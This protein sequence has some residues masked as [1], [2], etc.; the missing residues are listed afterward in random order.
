MLE[1]LGILSGF[2]GI[3]LQ[4]SFMFKF[5]NLG[6]IG[7]NQPLLQITGKKRVSP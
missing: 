1:K 7:G 2:V 4:P 5:R 6:D 3:I